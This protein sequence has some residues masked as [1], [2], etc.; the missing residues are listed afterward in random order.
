MQTQ[1]LPLS[2]P[3]E[4]HFPHVLYNSLDLWVVA[5]AR[6]HLPGAFDRLGVKHTDSVDD[7]VVACNSE[8]CW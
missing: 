4:D 7:E 1:S 6:P 5:K 8:V 2:A 3:L